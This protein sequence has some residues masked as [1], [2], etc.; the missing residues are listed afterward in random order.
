MCPPVN[1]HR[2]CQ[3]EVGKLVPTRSGV[4]FRVNLNLVRGYKVGPAR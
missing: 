4:I 2:L 1:E 3:I